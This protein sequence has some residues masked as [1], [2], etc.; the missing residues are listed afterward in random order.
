MRICSIAL[1]AALLGT[2]ALAQAQAADDQVDERPGDLPLPERLDRALRDM[3]EGVQ[4]TLEDALDY[5][6]SFG[7][8]DDPRHYEMPEIL[9]NGDII[10][11]R[12]DDAPEFHPEPPDEPRDA[13]PDAPGAPPAGE[14]PADPEEG[15]RT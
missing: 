3:M 11:R 14:Q 9:P 6:R 5:L 4:P 7:A 1:A 12:R 2:A 13:Q 8:V 10:I 15:V